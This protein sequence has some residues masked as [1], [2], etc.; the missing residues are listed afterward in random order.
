MNEFERILN[1]VQALEEKREQLL[2]YYILQYGEENGSLIRERGNKIIYIFESTPDFN[3]QFLCD[4]QDKVTNWEEF[5]EVEEEAIDYCKKRKILESKEQ[6]DI[7][8]LFCNYH[9]ISY[10]QNLSKIESILSLIDNIDLP[11]YEIECSSLGIRPLEDKEIIAKL[12]KKKQK[13]TQMKQLKLMERSLWGKNLKDAF[14]KSGLEIDSDELTK[15]LAKL[16]GR[17]HTGRCYTISECT[18]VYI[19]IIER[20]QQ[21]GSIDRIFL[22]ENRHAIE[23]GQ[24]CM[25]GITDKQKRLMMINEI[26]TEKHAIEDDQNF[27]TIFSK[28]VTNPNVVDYEFLF[29]FCKDLFEE[30]QYL[31]DQCALENNINNLDKAFSIDELTKYDRMLFDAYNLIQRQIRI[32]TGNL[33]IRSTPYFEM[34]ERLKVNAQNNGFKTYRK[35]K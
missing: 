31:F 19:P 6:H 1:P 16:L 15:L 4:N 14:L 3:F 9:N 18:F 13:I 2:N 33:T 22:H 23:S 29:N 12:I 26:R 11:K 27:P 8:T 34:V 7:Y 32:G 21:F 35:L 5:D 30:Y 25:I 24:N 17:E 28:K 10:Q 20:Y